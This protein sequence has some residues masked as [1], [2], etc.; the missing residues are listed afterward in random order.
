[1]RLYPR[2]N[3]TLDYTVG[4]G[5]I[6]HTIANGGSAASA[7]ISPIDFPNNTSW[8]TFTNSFVVGFSVGYTGIWA[9]ARVAIVTSS[10]TVRQSGAYTA[11]Q[12]VTAGGTKTFAPSI[13]LLVA[14]AVTDRYVVE[15]SIRNAS[16][17]SRTIGIAMS[18]SYVDTTLVQYKTLD[19]WSIAEYEAF[20]NVV[21]DVQA[22]AIGGRIKV[23]LAGVWVEK[24]IKY[25]NGS[26]WVEKPLKYHN[27]T[28]WVLT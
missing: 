19:I 26:A 7:F 17:V 24:P 25:Y 10:G 20:D 2:T 1:M 8:E 27:G 4:T 16:G 28:T 3:N 14:P 23:Y 5:S 6:S 21:L 22:V 13:T 12:Q 15:V 9:K 18:S 11:E